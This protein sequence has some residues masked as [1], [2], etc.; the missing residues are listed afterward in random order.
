MPANAPMITPMNVPT[1]SPTSATQFDPGRLADINLPET[2]S[3]WPVAPGW[4][5]LLGLVIIIIFLTIYLIKR[6]PAIPTPTRKELKSQAM[7]ELHAIKAAYESQPP[8]SE[9]SAHDCIKK[10]SIFLRR[11]ALSLYQRENVASLTDEDWL[12]LLD[13]IYA[14]NSNKNS[15]KSSYTSIDEALFSNKFASLLTQAPYQSNTKAID[16]KLLTELFSVSEILITNSFKRFTPKK[17][18]ESKHV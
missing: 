8:Q 1:E 11:Y 4:W 10:L 13:Q 6:K 9:A 14:Y 7:Q 5:I 17:P 3:F 2:I 16:T 12:S 18:V 15:N